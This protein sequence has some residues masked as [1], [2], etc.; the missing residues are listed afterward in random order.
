MPSVTLCHHSEG[1]TSYFVFARTLGAVDLLGT[2]LAS[3]RP[4]SSLINF[5]CLMSD[6][7]Q[8]SK[9]ISRKLLFLGRQEEGQER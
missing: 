7:H 1:K 2:M 6:V 4:I 3:H 8:I 5:T 9:Q